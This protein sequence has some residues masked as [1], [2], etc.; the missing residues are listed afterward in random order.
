MRRRLLL[1]L[2]VALFGIGFG[3]PPALADGGG[4]NTAIAIN[5]KDGSSIFKL[6]FSIKRVAGDV[7]DSTNAA[8]AFA[9]CNDC[10]TVAVAIEVVLVTGDPSTVTPTNLALAMN[11]DC[12]SCITVADAYQFVIGTGGEVP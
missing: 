6:A 3:A 2:V 11:V 8:V 9:S 5:T 7:V 12:Q 10:S 1:I 4:D